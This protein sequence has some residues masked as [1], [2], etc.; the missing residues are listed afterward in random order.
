[1]DIWVH[2]NDKLLVGNNSEKKLAQASQ[3]PE[4]KEF[5]S[6]SLGND[7]FKP[8]ATYLHSSG[9]KLPYEGKDPAPDNKR[10]YSINIK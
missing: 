6:Y 5:F 4:H 10:C 1:M 8:C 7:F 9:K 3:D 2:V